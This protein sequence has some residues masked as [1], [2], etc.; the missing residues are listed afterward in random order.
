MSRILENRE[1]SLQMKKR[2]RKR[3]LAF[4]FSALVLLVAFFYLI[5]VKSGAWLV[6]DDT[7]THVS[8]VVILDG[9]TADMERSD[10]AE[11]L[12]SENRADS[13]LVLGRRVFRD[14]SNA[15]FYAEDLLR[16]GLDSSRIF[17][18]RHNDPSS[19]EEALSIIPWLKSRTKSPVLLLTSA[20]ASRRVA[21]LFNTLSGGS[22]LFI[23]TDIHHF[24]YDAKNWTASRE[25]RKLW[26]RET[27]A[28]IHSFWDLLFVS[29]LEIAQENVPQFF[30]LK[31]EAEKKSIEIPAEISTSEKSLGNETKTNILDKD[32]ASDEEKDSDKKVLDEDKKIS[33]A[34]Q[35]EINPASAPQ[36]STPSNSGNLSAKSNDKLEN[37]NQEKSIQKSTPNK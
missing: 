37:K 12:L 18:C 11:K 25:S 23:T 13:V 9:Q 17:I 10:F 4:L 27:L 5:V 29:P 1:L 7:F 14:K 2:K 28:L 35:S 26:L 19:I 32:K 30:S 36:N 31:D 20:P 16:T 6:Q 15:D 21:H 22:P 3:T 8:W 34:A 24:S 33:P